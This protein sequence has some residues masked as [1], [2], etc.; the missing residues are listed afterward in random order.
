MDNRRK[1]YSAAFF[2]RSFESIFA[3]HR[4]I[5]QLLKTPKS[6]SVRSDR[7]KIDKTRKIRKNLQIVE[8]T[9]SQRGFEAK[10][11]NRHFRRFITS[12]LTF[13]C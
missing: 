8:F 12:I 2:H 10:E 9:G 11:S 4:F 6:A 13:F 1:I 3:V 7:I 5:V